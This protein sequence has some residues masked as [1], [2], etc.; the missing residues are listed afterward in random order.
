MSTL[1]CRM[2]ISQSCR[3]R[4]EQHWPKPGISANGEMGSSMRAINQDRPEGYSVVIV[5]LLYVTFLEISCHH[6]NET[7]V[8]ARLGQFA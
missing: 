8:I 6:G 7:H 5:V 4:R 2:Q 3:D 1:M